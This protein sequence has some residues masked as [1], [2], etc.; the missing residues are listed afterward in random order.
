MSAKTAE[1]ILK[2]QQL[3]IYNIILTTNNI[4]LTNNK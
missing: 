1:I 2:F 3:V 4:T